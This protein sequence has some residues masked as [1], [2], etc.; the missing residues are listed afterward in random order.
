[1]KKPLYSDWTEAPRTDCL[2]TGEPIDKETLQH[3]KNNSG[4]MTESIIQMYETADIINGKPLHDTIHKEHP[5]APWIYAGQCEPQKEINKNPALMP[6]VY[7]CS[8]YRADTRDELELN[9]EI[10]K[11]TCRKI[12]E[13]GAIPIAPHLYFPRFM[14]DNMPDERYFGM[15]AGKR[16]MEQCV[17]FHVVTVDGVISEGMREEIEYATGTLLMEGSVEFYTHEEAEQI[18]I[19]RM[20]R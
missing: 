18:R 20:E 4:Y 6:M 13:N 14:D 3:F 17:T 12:A 1:M 7:V 11:H 2:Q 16:L 10:A 15:G 9:I 19:N 5:Y 8:R